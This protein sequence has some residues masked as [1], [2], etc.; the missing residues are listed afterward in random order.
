MT[1]EWKPVSD[2]PGYEVSTNGKVRN[3]A[4]GQGARA[5]H[6]L[7]PG[8]NK[9]GYSVVTLRKDG[10]TTSKYVHDLVA[11]A[12]IGARKKGFTVNHKDRNRQNNSLKNLER[13]KGSDNFGHGR[14]SKENIRV[15]KR[16]KRDKKWTN[17]KIAK[18]LKLQPGVVA[19]VLRNG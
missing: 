3:V 5:G 14:V 18:A 15:I 16:M 10:L 9:R 6:V 13:I 19:T 12:F 11:D 8:V 4:G 2:Y 17:A 1:E 7:K